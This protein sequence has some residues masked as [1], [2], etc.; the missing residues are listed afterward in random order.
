MEIFFLEGKNCIKLCECSNGGECDSGSGNCQCQPGFQ[1]AKC[2]KICD[3]QSFGLGCLK[4]CECNGNSC[5]PVSGD[6]LCFKPGFTGPFCNIPCPV[7]TWGPGCI[8]KC[9]CQNNGTCDHRNGAD[10]FKLHFLYLIF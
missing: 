8:G 4:K 7:G 10:F 1:G 9:N 5:D 2:E 6:C 3:S